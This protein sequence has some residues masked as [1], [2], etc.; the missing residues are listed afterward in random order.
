MSRIPFTG[1]L[2]KFTWRMLAMVLGGQAIVFLLG[3]L[4]AR[5]S[6]LAN[7]TGRET[8]HLWIFI[9]LAALSFVT[10]GLMRRP[11]GLPL[12]WFVQ[13]LTWLSAFIVPIMI[14]VAIVFTALWVLCLFLG[15]RIDAEVAA[16]ENAADA[17]G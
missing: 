2:G 9:G 3:S 4:V 16:R 8:S 1:T 7:D 17:A 12:G 5:G 13:L 11:V 6:A 14:G 10:A 15:T